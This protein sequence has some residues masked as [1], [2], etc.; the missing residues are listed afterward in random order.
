MRFKMNQSP[1]PMKVSNQDRSD[2]SCPPARPSAQEL[3]E[4]SSRRA[5]TLVRR[6][7]RV[8]TYTARH[9]ATNHVTKNG[10]TTVYSVTLT[11]ACRP[12]PGCAKGM[13]NSFREGMGSGGR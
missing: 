7:T 13:P 10:L 8:V 11:W 4:L 9:Q 2:V 3:W 1:R 6:A 5:Y 12:E